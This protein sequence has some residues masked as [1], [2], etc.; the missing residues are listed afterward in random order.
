[1]KA[2]EMFSYN[3]QE[4]NGDSVIFKLV[5]FLVN[6]PEHGIEKGDYFNYLIYTIPNQM[7][8]MRNLQT[9]R[10]IKIPAPKDFYSI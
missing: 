9:K 4:S 3:G 1:M 7:L 2:E 10:Y 6:I 5:T 8:G